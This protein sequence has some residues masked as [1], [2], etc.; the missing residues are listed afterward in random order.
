MANVRQCSQSRYRK[1]YQRRMETTTPVART[2]IYMYVAAT[3]RGIITLLETMPVYLY[4][5]DLALRQVTATQLRSR[6]RS[7]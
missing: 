5:A 3:G 6:Q 1:V 2:F 7:G 4:K